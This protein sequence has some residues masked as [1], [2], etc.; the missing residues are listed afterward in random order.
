MEETKTVID[1]LEIRMFKYSP[2]CLC[3]VW[4]QVSQTL[5]TPDSVRRIQSRSQR[6]FYGG[7][8]QSC[9]K[10]V[11]ENQG[12]TWAKEQRHLEPRAFESVPCP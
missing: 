7:R 11:Q 6:R 4:I 2:S 5:S 1:G 9:L 12:G 10:Q 8:V 3:R